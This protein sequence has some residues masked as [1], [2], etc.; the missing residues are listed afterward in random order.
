MGESLWIGIAI[1]LALMV[2]LLV[3]GTSIAMVIGNRKE[4]RYAREASWQKFPNGWAKVWPYRGR[5]EA[6][7]SG[8]NAACRIMPVQGEL[9]TVEGFSSKLYV[10]QFSDWLMDRSGLQDEAVITREI[11]VARQAQYSPV[12]STLR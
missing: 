7:D 5:I 3:V 4:K 10:M 8:T 6:T 1:G 9:I 11:V 2:G 12:D